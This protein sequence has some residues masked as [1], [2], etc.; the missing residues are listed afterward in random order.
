MS[1]FLTKRGLVALVAAANGEVPEERGVD[2]EPVFEVAR[3]ATLATKGMP[4]AV[5]NIAIQLAVKDFLELATKGKAEVV[6]NTDL[7]PLGHPLSTTKHYLTNETVLSMKADWLAADPQLE[8]GTR[9]LLRHAAALSNDVSSKHAQARLRVLVASGSLPAEFAAVA[10][11]KD[12]ADMDT[13]KESQSLRENYYNSRDA[14]LDSLNQQVSLNTG[15]N[16]YDSD[17]KITRMVLRDDTKEKIKSALMKNSIF[18]SNMELLN[19]EPEDVYEGINKIRF[20]EFYQALEDMEDPKEEPNYREVAVELLSKYDENGKIAALINKGETS[21]DIL[22]ALDDVPAWSDDLRDY[23]TRAD[24]EVPRSE[25]MSQWQDFKS[26]IE[27]VMDLDDYVELEDSIT[28]ALTP[29][30]NK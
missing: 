6:S 7:L 29:P 13:S 25:Q 30:T 4:N 28:A 27:A 21:Y 22:K 5:Q 10:K 8:E 2:L 26:V 3:R 16:L 12:K 19:S 11:D 9:D 17:K 20:E 24:V 23:M 18:K 1:E 14:F 15:T